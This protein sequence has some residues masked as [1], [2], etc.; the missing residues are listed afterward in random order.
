MQQIQ[1][2]PLNEA[3]PLLLT[4]MEVIPDPTTVQATERHDRSTATVSTNMTV[5]TTPGN[6]PEMRD[7]TTDR[8]PDH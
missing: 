3:S 2:A 7:Q 4:R 6:N 5:C 1:E 8:N